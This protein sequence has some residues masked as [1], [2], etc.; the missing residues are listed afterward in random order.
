MSFN[1]FQVAEI[2]AL[3]IDRGENGNVTFSEAVT[4]EYL[5][6]DNHGVIYLKQQLDYEQQSMLEYKV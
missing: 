3:D 5:L 2:L 4:S 1:F 6:I